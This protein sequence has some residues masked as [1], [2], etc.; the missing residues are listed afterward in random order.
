VLIRPYDVDICLLNFFDK[1]VMMLRFPLI[2]VIFFSLNVPLAIADH[3]GKPK[4]NGH[5]PW[6]QNISVLS[7]KGFSTNINRKDEILIN[8]A[9]VANLIE[10]KGKPRVYFQWLPTKKSLQSNFDHI[11]FV[12]FANGVWSKPEVIKIPFRKREQYPVDPTVVNLED[13]S[14]RMYFTTRSRKGTHIGS[15]RSSDGVS[16]LIEEGKRFTEKHADLKDCAVI[17]FKGKWHMILP[18]HKSN[19]KGFYATSSNGLD[20]ARQ[21]D[22]SLKVRGDWLGNMLLAN[23]KVYFYGTG[24]IASTDDFK[25]WDLVSNHRLQDPAVL[26][27]EEKTIIVSTT[28]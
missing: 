6:D 5:G 15:A 21:S 16:F 3:W 23:D 11:A 28:R 25:K 27:F 17:L 10:Y 20:F 1:G 12:E 14:I 2:V 13:G 8:Q 18:T 7:L 19:G 4:L 24:F 22:V 26:M 9:G